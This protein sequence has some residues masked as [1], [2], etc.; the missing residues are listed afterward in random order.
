MF[1]LSREQR[2]IY[3]KMPIAMAVYGLDEHDHVVCLCVSDGMCAFT[4]RSRE[5]LTR[6]MNQAMFSL[7]HP[8]DAGRLEKIGRDFARHLCEYDLVYR[9]K[10]WA[11]DENYRYVHTIGAWQKMP[12]GQE[13]AM[14]VYNSVD[15]AVSVN[16]SMIRK[17]QQLQKDYFYTDILTKLPN[18]NFMRA[19]GGEKI[20]QCL[21]EAGSAAVWYFDV[22]GMHAFNSRYGLQEGD[23][24]LTAA[25][26]ALRHT[27][28]DGLVCRG[29]D[30][31]FLVVSPFDRA[32]IDVL[33]QK[34][35]EEVR[36][37]VSEPV[38]G[39]RAGICQA[40]R[41]MQIMEAL[42][43]AH[44]SLKEIGANLNVMWHLYTP[45]T[46][47]RSMM[48]HQ[49]LTGFQ[50][51]LEQHWIQPY[52][53]PIID[54]RT[55]Q[56]VFC[57]SLARWK[58]PSL[59][60]LQP[61][62]FIP[63]LRRFHLLYRL[64]LYILQ[65]VC[66]MLQERRAKQQKIVPVSV[67]F[68]RQD[69]DMPDLAARIDGIVTA[70]HLTPESIMIEITEQDI[71]D[72]PDRMRA[73]IED[74]HR[75][76]YALWMDDFGS[77]YSSLNVMDEF[78]FDLIKFDQKLLMNRNS[79]RR[80]NSYILTAMTSIA[81]QIGIRSLAEGLEKEDDLRFLQQIGCQYAQG[82]LFYRPMEAASLAVLLEEK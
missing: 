59:G 44:T 45:E 27:F 69:F 47:K 12:D 4:K 18:A 10:T 67:N 33:M 72:A 36:A 74:I 32:K 22:C 28:L 50:E 48:S 3:E 15:D 21:L 41:H 24:L 35:N 37:S 63:V 16:Y 78:P 34:I 82:F 13:L 9:L 6:L 2:E 40:D 81:G 51:A 54:V 75:R 5:D 25:A 17:Y 76:G 39:L 29:S 11:S 62:T 52:F 64:D 19:F 1:S 58:D 68:S 77:G 8:E 55:G 61:G 73:Q 79:G 60:M 42:D 49:L 66:R 56:I 7:V 80:G 70:S 14:L 23:R 46:E 43:N 71:S 38:L 31:H 65:Q 26:H 30:D 53:Q 57:E 20:H